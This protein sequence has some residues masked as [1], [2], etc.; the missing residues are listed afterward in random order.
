MVISLLNLFYNLYYKEAQ[1]NRPWKND[2]VFLGIIE[3]IVCIWEFT[4]N[5]QC[6]STKYI[7]E[8][9]QTPITIRVWSFSWARTNAPLLINYNSPT[10]FLVTRSGIGHHIICITC[11]HHMKS[12]RGHT[13]HSLPLDGFCIGFDPTI[14]IWYRMICLRW[15]IVKWLVSVN[16]DFWNVEIW[17]I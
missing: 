6:S 9:L 14:S 17:P 16:K 10:I 13:L 2:L 7:A 11:V 1:G 3:L 5:A 8:K 4:G 15:A 12:Y